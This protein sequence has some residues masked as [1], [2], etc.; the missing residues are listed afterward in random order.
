MHHP[1][2]YIVVAGG[3]IAV[4]TLN[5]ENGL[6]VI[7]DKNYDESLASKRTAKMYTSST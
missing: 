4:K 7:F 5:C 6:F 2:Y 1:I 3:N